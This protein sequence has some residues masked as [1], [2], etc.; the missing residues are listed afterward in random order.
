MLAEVRFEGESGSGWQTATLSPV[1]D[2]TAGSSYTVSVHDP[3]GGYAV[4]R[5]FFANPFVSGQ[6]TATQGVYRYGEGGTMPTSS[7]GDSNYW[8]DVLYVPV[9]DEA[10]PAVTDRS[11]VVDAVDVPVD[12]VVSVTFDEAIESGSA[13]SVTPQGGSEV[14]GGT[15]WDEAS[16]TLTFTP[17]AAFA[18][19]TLYGVS[20]TGVADADGNETPTQDW[21]F[22]TAADVTAPVVESVVPVVDAVDVDPAAKVVLAVDEDLQ[23]GAA[24]SVADSQGGSVAGSTSWNVT[25][26]TLTFSPDALL[27]LGE[28]LTVAVTGVADL[29]G[30]VAD[31]PSWSFAVRS[32]ASSTIFDDTVPAVGSANDTGALEV[33]TVFTADRDGI[34]SGV[35][36]YKGD[37][38]IGTHVGRVYDA[39]DGSVLAEVRF[40]GESG[41]G[42]QTATLSP[43]LDV[44]A[45]SSYTVSVHD[46]QGGYAVERQFFANPFVSG[47]LTAT[48]GVYRYGEGGTMP[49]SSSGDS[50]YWVDVLYVPV[51][52]EA[53]PAVTDRSPVVD[54]VDV[55]VDAVV[56]VTFDEAIESGS[57]VSVTPQGGS[58]VEGGTVWDEASLTLTFTPDAAFAEGTLYGVSVT[59]VADADGNETPTQD[60]SFTTAAAG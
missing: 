25:H 1:L 51:A 18:E 41:S 16:L 50:N 12:A 14:E 19:G 8:V 60:W 26:Q 5:Q 36:F 17:D 38:N 44:T 30:N 15:V 6:L 24:V 53:A 46:P 3:Q 37:A 55:P 2:V 23:A 9:A 58:E 28:T 22:T 48:Q 11:P 40:E 54:A 13:V 10:A 34:V 31:V 27:P 43:V 59:G 47:Q 45:G 4:E 32:V 42:W 35:R 20:V 21:S 39:S 52:D 49:T 57:A 33:G 29:A 56:S 7:S